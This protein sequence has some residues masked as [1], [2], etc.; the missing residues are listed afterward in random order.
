[1]NKNNSEPWFQSFVSELD[2]SLAEPLTETEA[3]TIMD[4]YTGQ[5]IEMTPFP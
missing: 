2:A 5:K 1:M 3:K 4:L